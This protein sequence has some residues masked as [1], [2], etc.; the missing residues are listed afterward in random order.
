M[1]T[2]KNLS[3]EKQQDEFI[4]AFTYWLNCNFLHIGNDQYRE[5]TDPRPNNTAF[6][7]SAAECLDLFRKQQIP[8]LPPIEI[9]SAAKMDRTILSLADEATRRCLALFN[10]SQKIN[11]LLATTDNVTKRAIAGIIEEAMT[12]ISNPIH[13]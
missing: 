12:E 10:C 8:P 5:H 6:L 9:K 7:R 13:P 3:P 11:Y 1:N 4:L 2:T